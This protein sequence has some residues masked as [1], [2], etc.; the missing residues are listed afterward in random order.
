MSETKGRE[1]LTVCSLGEDKEGQITRN[2]L[3]AVRPDA[4]EKKKSFTYFVIGNAEINMLCNLVT[5]RRARER[6]QAK[7]RP[8]G[9]RRI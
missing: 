3:G 5:V 2:G 9:I 1:G 4:H 7:Y 6:Y 8:S